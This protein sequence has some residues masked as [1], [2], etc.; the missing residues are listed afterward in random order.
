MDGQMEGWING[1]QEQRLREGNG[2][3]EDVA[4]SQPSQNICP[5]AAPLP[6]VPSASGSGC[7]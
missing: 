7:S 6:F 1:Y 3:V 5:V 4:V 2:V